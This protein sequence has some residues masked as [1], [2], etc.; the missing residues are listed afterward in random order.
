MSTL[1]ATSEK[2]IFR[3]ELKVVG[4]LALLLFAVEAG[5][6]LIEE[7]LSI[8]IQHMRSFDEI[9]S[10]VRSHG[11]SEQIAVQRQGAPG[12]FPPQ[13]VFLGNSMT[14]YGLDREAFAAQL[15]RTA[16]I[17]ALHPDNSRISEW[18]YL[19]RNLIAEQNRS[20]E[21][22]VVGFA[23]NQLCDAASK[24]P[25]RIARFYHCGPED[26]D[27]IARDDVHGLEAWSHFFCARYSATYAN[28]E[29]VERR[30]LGSLIPH[31]QET[32]NLLN[33][34][35]APLE[36]Q[37]STVAPT[38]RR[39]TEFVQLA[40][41]DHVQVVLVAMPTAEP[42]ALDPQLVQ[43]SFNSGITLMDCR[44]VPGVT[45]EMI[46]DGLHLTPAGATRY[47]SYLAQWLPL[48]QLVDRH[49]RLWQAHSAPQLQMAA[50]P[51]TGIRQQ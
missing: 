24:T 36:L 39:L 31:Y 20:P 1:P 50:E 18:S 22:L 6:Q 7:R 12:S 49:D 19:Y 23:K 15:A 30:I 44:Q 5:L 14:R 34:Q 35:S 43:L 48:K 4:T 25:D 8:D 46:P 27:R 41:R 3:T 10:H 21:L 2:Q 32:S 33:D 29:R 51:G 17:V 38:Y 13:I 47:S 40:Q 28:R 11:D 45:S 16:E 9:A 26:F 37:G 42:Y